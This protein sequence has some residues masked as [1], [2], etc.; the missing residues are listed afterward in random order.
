MGWIWSS[1]STPAKGS[2]PNSSPSEQTSKPAPAAKQSDYDDPEIAKFMAQL[3]AEFS[4]SSNSNSKP[5]QSTSAPE[6][7]SK[8]PPT[9][10]QAS[11][12]K[13][14]QS[15]WTQSL[16]G[17]SKTSPPA[18]NPQSQSQTNNRSTTSDLQPWTPER[19]DPVTE[20][21]LP[22]TMSCRQAFDSAYH[23]NSVGGQ[24]T[25][26]YRSGAVRSCSE[27]WEDFWFCM[28][29]RAYS[30]PQ[31]E[32]AIRA[33]YRR[34]EYAK[35][36]APGQPSSTDVWEPR[37]RKVEPGTEFQA[38]LVMPN[39]SDEEWRMAEIER[40]RLVQEMLRSESS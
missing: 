27:H 6:P 32:D 14:S 11:P 28:R 35:Y 21:L 24:W 33:H 40:R 34:R 8:P 38:P 4:G 15:S 9:P 23:C 5:A 16:W 36:Y 10:P 7:S 29:T 17:P 39:L 30:G 2:N 1:S 20:S 31:K 37:E 3:Q 25:S 19:L 22:T 26:V 12:S 18:T 13:P